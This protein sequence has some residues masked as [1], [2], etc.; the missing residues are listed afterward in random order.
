MGLMGTGGV[1]YSSCKDAGSWSVGVGMDFF[2][3]Y[4]AE[5]KYAGYFGEIETNPLDG[6]VKSST[7]N[8]FIRDRGFVSLTLKTSF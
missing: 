8:G 2:Q 7:G 4:K 6:S 1:S 5:L 3:K